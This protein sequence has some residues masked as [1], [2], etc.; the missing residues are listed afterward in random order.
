MGTTPTHGLSSAYCVCEVG[1]KVKVRVRR[2][3]AKVVRVTVGQSTVD[4]VLAVAVATVAI[5]TPPDRLLLQHEGLK[6]SVEVMQE[7][8]ANRITRFKF[9]IQLSNKLCLCV[10]RHCT[11]I[12]FALKVK[13]LLTLGRVTKL[14]TTVNIHVKP[15]GV[16]TV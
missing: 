13:R 9:K 11:I 12:T 8:S 4:V 16:Q 3:C 5:E 14:P 7:L 15:T 6:V 1:V 10:L 2:A